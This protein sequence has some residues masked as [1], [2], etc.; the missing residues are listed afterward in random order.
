MPELAELKLTADVINKTKEI[1]FNQVKKN[2]IHKCPDIKINYQEFKISS[3]SRGKELMLNI[4][5]KNSTDNFKVRMTMGMSGFFAITKKDSLYKHSHLSFYS[6]Y[7][8]IVLSFVDVRR[9]GKWKIAN[10]WSKNRGPDPVTEYDLF[11]EN[12]KNNYNKRA[13]NKPICEFLMNQKWCNG[14]GNY[15]RAEVLYRIPDLNPWTSAREAFQKFPE[16]FRLCKEI[17]LRAYALGGGELK[18]WKNQLTESQV[19]EDLIKC[20]SVKGM[21]SIKDSNSR[22]FWYDPKWDKINKNI[23]G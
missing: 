21:S 10:N 14:L 8:D 9:F 22:R 23:D 6:K 3:E 15:I 12:I 5:D 4:S 2:P 19:K 17:P 20:Y 7:H 1:T 18:T 11:V 16:L 13:F